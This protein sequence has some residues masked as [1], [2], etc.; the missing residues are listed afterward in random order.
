MNELS[1]II[2]IG[3]GY[4][5][6]SVPFGLLIGRCKGIDIRKH[7][8]GNVGATNCGRVLGR[9]W[10]VF[11]FLL[12]LLKGAAPVLAAGWWLGPLHEREMTAAMAGWWLGVAMAPIIGHVWPVWL[13]F[14]GG[15]GVATG[16]GVI[17]GIWPYLTI[18]AIGAGLTWLLLLATFRYVSLA[19]VVAALVLPLYFALA[20][21]AEGW[22]MAWAWPFMAVT[23]AMALLVIA[24][25]RGNLRRLWAGTESRVG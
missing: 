20:A 11:C 12:D 15:K 14:R 10:G 7:G 19:S 17:L 23:A 1:G 2:A 3:I 4:I 9:S 6:G 21:S 22:A 24:R 18:P 16:F 5:C 25:H 13:R 8:S